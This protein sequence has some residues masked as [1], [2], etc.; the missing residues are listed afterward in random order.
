MSFLYVWKCQLCT[1]CPYA[2]FTLAVILTGLRHRLVTL[3]S[4]RSCLV[5]DMPCL[6]LSCR[7]SLSA[8]MP[9]PVSTLELGL[10]RART[11]AFLTPTACYPHSK[12]RRQLLPHSVGLSPLPTTA[13]TLQ[14]RPTM[15]PL[16]QTLQAMQ[17]PC[18]PTQR[19]ELRL[20]LCKLQA[21]QADPSGITQT[22]RGGG[23]ALHHNTAANPPPCSPAGLLTLLAAGLL[24][25][26]ST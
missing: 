4:L 15:L 1:C 9:N 13:L 7:T 21:A 17:P 18:C 12:E 10:V 14:L 16:L 20:S 11:A 22:P 26:V 5:Q 24:P 25:P 6:A 2:G 19:L 3:H 8:A 23:P